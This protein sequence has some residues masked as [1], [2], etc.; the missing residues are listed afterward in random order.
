MINIVSE[1]S[2]DDEADDFLSLAGRRV[3]CAGVGKCCGRGDDIL[4]ASF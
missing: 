3:L 2:F 4:G 1:E